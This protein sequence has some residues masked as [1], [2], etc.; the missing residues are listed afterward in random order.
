[1]LDSMT[2]APRPTRAEISDVAN[3]A[4]DHTDATMLSQESAVGQYPVETV[5]TMSDIIRDTE[6][7]PLDD[8]VSLPPMDG[9]AAPVHAMSASACTVAK[10]IGAKAIV[11][12]TRSGFTARAVS[13]H[14][15]QLPMIAITNDSTVQR[16]LALSWGI[17]PW[18]RV[19]LTDMN[20]IGQWAIRQ[21]RSDGRVKAGE[22]VVMVAGLR[23]NHIGE[24]DEVIRVLKA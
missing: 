1:M 22:H 5:T 2:H 11:I 16:Q 17:E 8:M 24:W 20:V 12:V 18:I 14:R 23:S 13:R 10:A 4:I 3:A 7:S 9:S 6:A 21:L 19:A 15:P